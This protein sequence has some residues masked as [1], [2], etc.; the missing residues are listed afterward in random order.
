MAIAEKEGI[1]DL[2]LIH[3]NPLIPFA[4]FN[5]VSCHSFND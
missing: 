2:T 5:G 3:L 1:V 4:S